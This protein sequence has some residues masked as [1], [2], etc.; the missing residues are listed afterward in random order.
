MIT[1]KIIRPILE[2]FDSEDREWYLRWLLWKQRWFPYRTCELGGF[3]EETGELITGP[4]E[5]HAPGKWTAWRRGK[6]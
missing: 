2:V 4:W 1:R 6:R 5:W 3:D